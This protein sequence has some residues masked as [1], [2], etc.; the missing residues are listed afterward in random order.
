MGLSTCRHPPALP[1]QGIDAPRLSMETGE[2][3]S[4]TEVP[5]LPSGLDLPVRLR[6]G[7][8]GLKMH[9]CSE[10]AALCMGR[11][12]KGAHTCTRTHPRIP[13][14][15]P[16]QGLQMAPSGHVMMPIPASLGYP[17]F[18]SHGPLAFQTGHQTGSCGAR[19]GPSNPSSQQ[20]TC[21]TTDKYDIS[22]SSSFPRSPAQHITA[23]KIPTD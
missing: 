22:V 12:H 9:G 2:W 23:Q 5:E 21:W 4:A 19:Q 20:G 7:P 16:H 8:C 10:P 14:W 17:T 18:I 1:I 13:L 15:L 3:E 11:V 6:T